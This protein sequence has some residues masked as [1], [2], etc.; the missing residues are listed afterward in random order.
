MTSSG[1]P[2]P[3]PAGRGAQRRL[4]AGA[5]PAA[6]LPQPALAAPPLQPNEPEKTRWN[7]GLDRQVGRQARCVGISG[8]RGALATVGPAGVARATPAPP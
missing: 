5:L 7:K 2:A 6:G 8:G 1:A 3:R 4:Q